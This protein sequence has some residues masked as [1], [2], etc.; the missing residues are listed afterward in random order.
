MALAPSVAEQV[1]ALGLQGR[2]AGVTDYCNC[3]PEVSRLPTVGSYV[4]PSLEACAALRPDVAIAA[5][6][7]RKASL[8]R[9]RVLG[10]EVRV[11]DPHTVEQAVASLANVARW[12]GAPGAERR[13][14][15]QLAARLAAV[16][17]AVAGRHRPRV[18]LQLGCGS[19][20][21]AGAGS[22]QDDLIREA[23]GRNVAGCLAGPYLRLSLELLL[24]LRPEV[25]L[26]VVE[27]PEAF[28]AERRRWLALP[29]PAAR[30]GAI[31]AVP[32]D[33]LQRPGPR[34]LDGLELTAS[35]LHHQAIKEAKKP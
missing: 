16:R 7:T 2:L 25:I 6:G 26:I 33:P 34:L 24:A 22:L 8:R 20:Y 17:R 11:S 12:C 10:V 13:L 3:P 31:Y 5:F 27:D 21:T 32:L 9:L 14:A 1:Y 29:L 19:L 30:G 35:L 23:G 15:A 28:A 4:N 18:L